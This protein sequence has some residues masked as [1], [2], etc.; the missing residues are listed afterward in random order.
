MDISFWP[1]NADA[2]NIMKRILSEVLSESKTSYN[3]TNRELAYTETANLELPKMMAKI[4]GK[5]WKG[6]MVAKTLSTYMTLLG[7][8]LNSK[9]A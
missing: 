3:F 8:G 4:G 1:E 5:K 7:F 6:A 9:L 2:Q